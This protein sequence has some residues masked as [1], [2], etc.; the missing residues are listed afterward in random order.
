[1]AVKHRVELFIAERLNWRKLNSIVFDELYKLILLANEAFKV[2]TEVDK[3]TLLTGLLLIL[4]LVDLSD[5][6]DRPV[7]NLNFALV[8]IRFFDK[9][10]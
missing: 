7:S 9:V 6:R 10:Y 5:F 2:E 8:Q 4:H 3:P 1:M